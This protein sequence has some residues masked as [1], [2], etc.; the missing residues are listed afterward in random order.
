MLGDLTGKVA[1][2]TGAGQGIGQGIASVFARAGAGIVVATRSAGNGQATVD[3]IAATGGQAILIQCDVG[4]RSEVE[5]VVT[6]TLA[7]FGRVDI[8]IHNAAIYPLHTVEE[9]TDEVMEQTLAVNMK[10]AVW[11]TQACVPHFRKQGGGRLIFTS[12][13]TGPRVAMPGTAHYAMSKG[14]MNGF[15][16]TAALEYARE[17]ITVNGVEP[18][19]ILT[20]AMSAL[21]DEEQLNAM[22]QCIPQGH[23]G[24][25]ED[26]ANTMLF[27]ASREAGYITGQTIV[28]DGGST[29]PES[30]VVMDGFYG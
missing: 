24:T 1:I 30:Q 20:Q 16:R 18:G 27:L 10:A 28:V 14:G 2:V 23:L 22:A 6:E 21:G 5:R 13:V 3:D 19:Y 8:G 11:L 12:S 17:N 25:P 4:K 15:I 9:L 7:H 26:I 29:L